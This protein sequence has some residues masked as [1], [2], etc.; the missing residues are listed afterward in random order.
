MR[1]ARNAW[2]RN[3]TMSQVSTF[4]HFCV[5]CG[6][7]IDGEQRICVDCSSGS[8]DEKS[9]L[10]EK[11]DPPDSPDSDATIRVTRRS[12]QFLLMDERQDEMNEDAEKTVRVASHLSSRVYEQASAREDRDSRRSEGGRP[13]GGQRRERRERR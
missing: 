3:K 12:F 10:L 11:E 4:Q 13:S 6:T 2:K 9:P 5:Q 8:S 7:A 1:G